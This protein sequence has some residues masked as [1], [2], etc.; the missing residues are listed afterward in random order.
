MVKKRKNKT[1]LEISVAAL[2]DYNKALEMNDESQRAKEG[3]RKVQKLKKQAGKRDYYKILGVGR[4]A[5]KR[6]VC[7]WMQDYL[8]SPLI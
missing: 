5:S 8:I 7:R 3:I 1:K 6:E 2:S 4:K